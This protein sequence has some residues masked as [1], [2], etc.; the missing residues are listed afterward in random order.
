VH[1]ALDVRPISL[2]SGGSHMH[3]RGVHFVATTSAGAKLVDTT[4]WDDS[5][6]SGDDIECQSPTPSGAGQVTNNVP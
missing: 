4:Q 6:P 2:I 3:S 1:G 5:A